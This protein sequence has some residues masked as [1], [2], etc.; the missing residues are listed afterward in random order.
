MIAHVGKK[1]FRSSLIFLFVVFSLAS[2]ATLDSFIDTLS[3]ADREAV[4]EPQPA[5]R[6]PLPPMIKDFE[7]GNPD[8]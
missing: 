2:C 5:R 6:V 8:A 1:V 4:G 7:P 3:G